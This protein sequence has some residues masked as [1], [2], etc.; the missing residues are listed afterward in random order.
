VPVQFITFF[1][2]I[3][4]AGRQFYQELCGLF[5]GTTWGERQ[6]AFYNINNFPVFVKKNNI[7]REENKK[8]MNSG[9]QNRFPWQIKNKRIIKQSLVFKHQAPEPF[10]GSIGNPDF[11]NYFF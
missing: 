4:F 7:N 1:Y 6:E 10:P 3:G 2:A 11:E 5:W 8:H 9:L